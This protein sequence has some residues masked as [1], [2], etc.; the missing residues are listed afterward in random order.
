MDNFSG[1]EAM[2]PFFAVEKDLVGIITE[3]MKHGG[4]EV[5]RCHGITNGVSGMSVAFSVDVSPFGSATCEDSA[6]AVG[7]MFSAGVIRS[8]LG[9][10]SEFTYPSDDCIVEHAAFFEVF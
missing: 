10:S 9:S 1:A 5:L 2:R 6:V 7:P 4:G 3:K 8:D